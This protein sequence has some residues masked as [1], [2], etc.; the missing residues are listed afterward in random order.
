PADAGGDVRGQLLGAQRLTEDDAVDRLADHLLEARHVDT[1]LPRVEVDE[2]F[3]LGEEVVARAVS[4]VAGDSAMPADADHLLDAADADA[5]EAHLG[6][7]S[8]R[9]YVASCYPRGLSQLKNPLRRLR[10]WPD[11][12]G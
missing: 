2:A 11:G 12:Q 3:E 4:A 5:G 6:A 10:R 8:R 7:R 1:G 9:L